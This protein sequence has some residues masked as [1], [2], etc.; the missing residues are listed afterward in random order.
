MPTA[1]ELDSAQLNQYVQAAC[2]RAKSAPPARSDPAEER[3]L[4]QH[5]QDAAALLKER[6]GATRVVLFGSLAHRA[7]S[8]SDSDVDLAVAGL[9]GDDYWQAWREVEAVFGNRRVDLI[10]LETASGSLR[11]A[12]DRYG[13]AL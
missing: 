8:A 3:A 13:V 12:V 2:R 6:F 4:T 5:A 11:A 7:W 1:L 10:E 9:R